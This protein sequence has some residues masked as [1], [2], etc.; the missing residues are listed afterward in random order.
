MEQMG[1]ASLTF[2]ARRWQK[3]RTRPDWRDRKRFFFRRATIW[4]KCCD[5]ATGCIA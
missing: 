5:R 2:A 3:C 4:A 1:R